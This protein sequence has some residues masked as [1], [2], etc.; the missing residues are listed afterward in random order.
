MLGLLILAMGGL[1][2]A[3]ML[4]GDDGVTSANS[5]PDVEGNGDE[6]GEAEVIGLSE[7]LGPIY[8]DGID[9]NVSG[10]DA[11]D[12]IVVDT[13]QE[14]P[15]G[16]LGDLGAGDLYYDATLVEID[17]GNGNDH[18]VVESGSAII[19]TGEGTD[20]VDAHGMGAGVIYAESGDLVIGSDI[21]AAGYYGAPEIGVV[22]HSAIFEGG[23]A[24]E[25]TVAIGEGSQL[26][27]GG[28]NDVLHAYEGDILIDGGQ[29]NDTL[30]GNADDLRF[31]QCTRVADIDTWSN[32]SSDTLIGGEGDDLLELSRGDVGTGGPGEDIFRV[33]SNDDQALDAATITDFSP[34]EDTLVIQVGGGDPWD[35]QDP[36]YDLAERIS[37]SEDSGTTSVIVDDEVVAIIEGVTELNI[38]YPDHSSLNGY[39]TLSFINVETGE[40]GEVSSFHVIIKVFHARSS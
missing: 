9:G 30:L 26:S 20:T 10:T 23:T 16:Y 36:S 14:H 17:S 5:A 15:G 27:G 29:G 1:V 3:A 25:F 4:S 33:F 18:I 24:A 32:E 28:G 13:Q 6:Q 7:F 12:D 37:Y 19:S 31:C 40:V 21:E 39:E 22:A 38:G 2:S 34:S 11:A 35:Y 8:V